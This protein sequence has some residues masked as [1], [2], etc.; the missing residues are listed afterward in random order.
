MKKIRIF[1]RLKNTKDML[2]SIEYFLLIFCFH[3][4]D[5][6]NLFDNSI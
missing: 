3:N 2:Q 6:I 1:K 5:K 4:I